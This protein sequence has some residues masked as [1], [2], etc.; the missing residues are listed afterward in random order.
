MVDESGTTKFTYT[1]AG[2]LQTEDGPFDSDTVTNVY[3]NRMRTNL[4]LAQP[5]GVWVNTFGYSSTHRLNSV[6]SPAGTFSYDYAEPSTRLNSISLP[7]GAVIANSVY[8]A[9]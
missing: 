1:A 7:N 3:W 5:A 6:T 4:S 9:M 2:Q 8:D